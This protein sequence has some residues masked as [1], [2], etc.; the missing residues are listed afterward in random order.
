MRSIFLFAVC[1]F[2]ASCN[3][4]RNIGATGATVTSSDGAFS[5]SFLQTTNHEQKITV[6]YFQRVEDNSDLRSL[7]FSGRQG[8]YLSNSTSLLEINQIKSFSRDHIFCAFEDDGE[9]KLWE[10]QSLN[11]INL[12]RSD[13]KQVYELSVGDIN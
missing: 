2:V 13:P 9:L 11:S 5:L 12:S 6:I 4:T 8:F 1:V 3:K 10:S 7:L